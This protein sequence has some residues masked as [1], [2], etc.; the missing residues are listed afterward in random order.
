MIHAGTTT[1]RDAIDRYE[2]EMR[3]RTRRAVLLS[4]QACRDAHTWEQLDEQSAILT[5]RSVV[6]S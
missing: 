1:P 6:G 2:K 5:K 4:R 3:E